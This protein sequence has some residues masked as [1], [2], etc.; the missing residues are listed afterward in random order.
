[1][2][3]T[4]PLAHYVKASV[5]M[6]PSGSSLRCRALGAASAGVLVLALGAGAVSA[7]EG[8]VPGVRF[9]AADLM[10]P[11]AAEAYYASQPA[12]VTYPWASARPPEITE[13]AAA[14]GND[15]GRIFT[16]VRN[17]I[18]IV[19]IYGLQK[20]AVG[21]LVDRSGTSFDQ[22]QLLVEL[23]RAAGHP[24]ARYV[25]G[26]LTLTGAQLDEWLGVRTVS[27][28]TALLANG[29]IP[30]S[31]SGSGDVASVTLGHV[32]VQVEVGGVT[33]TY[34]PSYKPSDVGQAIDAK[35]VAGL[36]RAGFVST[37]LSGATAQSESG[38]PYVAGVNVA[39][40]EQALSTSAT[41]LLTQLRTTYK[42]RGGDDLTGARTIRFSE[43]PEASP[44][45]GSFSV[46]QSFTGGMPDRYR[47]VLSMTA[48]SCGRSFF[49]DEIYGRRLTL[50][51]NI[52]YGTAIGG[53]YVDG[54]IV[55]AGCGD[56]DSVQ[57]Y[58]I[59]LSVNHP[60]ATANGAYMDA[61]AIKYVDRY[62]DV[63]IVHGWGDT[64][65][66][67]QGKLGQEVNQERDEKIPDPVEEA[68]VPDGTIFVQSDAGTTQV[69]VKS[70]LGASWLAQASRTSELLETVSG[71]GLQHHHT[72]GVSYSQAHFFVYDSNKNRIADPGEMLGDAPKD[73]GMRLDLDS[74]YSTSRVT[75]DAADELATRHTLAAALAMLEG[76]VMEQ[77][78]DAVDT[79]STAQRLPWGQQ[80]LAS[81]I[82]YH[83]F[84]AG[85]AAPAV[86]TY[87]AGAAA[88]GRICAGSSLTTQG[89]SVL[90][91]N[92]RMLGPGQA[93]PV[94]SVWSSPNPWVPQTDATMHRG[95]AWI[96]FKADGSHI[97]HMVTSLDRGLKGGGTGDDAEKK[98]GFKPEKQ[99]DL[100]KDQY[101]DRSSING[102]DLRTGAFTFTPPADLK[103]G[104][105]EFP[106]SLSFQR[107]FQA[108]G[109]KCAGC[110]FGWTHNFDIR[111]AA[112]GGGLEGMG[113]TSP[114]ALAGPLTALEGAFALYRDN[115]NAAGNQLAGAA[116]MRWMSRQLN[117]NVVTV[118]QGPS[119]ETFVRLVDGSYAAPRGSAAQLTQAGE[120][121]T[122]L[123][124]G[125]RSL[126]WLYDQV[127]YSRRA[128]SGDVLQF[129]WREWNPGWMGSTTVRYPKAKAFGFPASTWTF[130]KGVSVT[131]SYCESQPLLYLQ[132]VSACRDRLTRVSNSLG[133][134]IDI[135][136]LTATG[137][138]GRVSSMPIPST[139]ANI[140][141]WEALEP[142]TLTEA[143]GGVWKFEW[144][145]AGAG[146]RPS[147]YPYLAKVYA[148]D[149]ATVAQQRI[150]YDRMN[151][152][153][154]IYD[155]LGDLGDRPSLKIHA[156]G[157][158]LGGSTDPSGGAVSI[159][160]D[161]KDR[162]V[163]QI[164]ELGRKS[165]SGYDSLGRVV[166]R[167]APEGDRTEFKY[168][169]RDNVIELRRVPKTGSLAAPLVVTAEYDPTW[170]KPR[171]I[172]DAR[173][174]TLADATYGQ[175]TD[176]TYK[177]SGG[178]AG[179]IETVT[180]PAVDGGRPV[181][182][183]EYGA[184]GLVTKVTD[185]T[186]LVAT[187][188]YDAK[189]NPTASTVDPAGVSSTTCKTFDGRGNLI[190]ETEARGGACS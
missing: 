64:G 50:H 181:W 104:G 145:R 65:N 148:P 56:T 156:P 162:V 6:I 41:T 105:G 149:N 163:R 42:E 115:P 184:L 36:S 49:V 67:L 140:Q 141:D 77:Q 155:R 28:A 102:A 55:G 150:V 160:Y 38:A 83:L 131:F 139:L 129:N 123:D 76:S 100:L 45:T 167:T 114:L 174:N 164:D 153:R 186:G 19:P 111:A 14:L 34:D 180:Q 90:Q 170:N 33:R 92:D 98:E 130:P 16:F 75:G 132:R 96:A 120:R 110:S 151:R 165:I 26:D 78:L 117:N 122:T 144:R 128:K 176:Y 7:Q 101:K 135:D 21:A 182:R 146:D 44:T 69:S 48:G 86:A 119:N 74:A 133:Y 58:A 11:S 107:T 113:S 188:L 22:A 190:S 12:T 127:S 147:P 30:A 27:A 24:S 35:A 47:T 5:S 175:Q 173:N 62:D 106:Y 171:W 79:A 178:G 103:I 109:T 66:E 177:A 88:S 29:A 112:S 179:E 46:R 52:S 39:G 124:P 57:S 99:A 95:C 51:R 189:G 169:E 97:A 82:R 73:S 70:K 40:I 68:N 3:R 168:D 85:I 43:A 93:N 8:T 1:M 32:L 142:E 159:L 87:S 89:F 37:A 15:P 13:A 53:V 158:G 187:T 121:R 166:S 91:A 161:T 17:N 2:S 138:D 4:I 60:Y 63:V 84:P 9:G 143:G 172:R 20:G 157:L 18:R 108:G 61:N 152:V 10:A 134:Y 118:T 54:V 25:V 72:L 94:P 116:V 59:N 126:T 23:L 137:S 31:I 80:N 154:E 183:Y 81:T 71:V 125:A 185:P 136:R